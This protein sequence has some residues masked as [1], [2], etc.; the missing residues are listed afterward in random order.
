MLI[1][2]EN[3]IDVVHALTLRNSNLR[4]N[5]SRY[6]RILSKYYCSSR[7]LRAYRFQESFLRF[8]IHHP[9]CSSLFLKGF[10]V[11]ICYEKLS[12]ESNLPLHYDLLFRIYLFLC[13]PKV[14]NR[15]F[16][17][18]KK[19]FVLLAPTQTA[20]QF[21]Q[22]SPL[23]T[24][25]TPNNAEIV[26][27]NSS[28]EYD[29][30]SG[31]IPTTVTFYNKQKL[32][33]IFSQ[34]PNFFPS[35]SHVFVKP[36]SRFSLI[37]HF[38]RKKMLYSISRHLK[39]FGTEYNGLI[40]IL[41]SLIKGKSRKIY[42]FGFDL[43][44]QVSRVKGYSKQISNKPAP[45]SRSDFKDMFLRSASQHDPAEQ[46]M[47]LYVL[48]KLKYFYPDKKLSNILENGLYSY[49]LNLSRSYL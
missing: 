30:N 7:F 19:N 9:F 33:S 26:R 38:K 15:C 1:R 45:S 49:L 17:P 21:F 8:Y 24:I 25:I 11:L 47:I 23:W 27:L 35:A 43:Q 5:F 20:T 28:P 32:I 18:L 6:K 13:R 14:L 22:E 44:L 41:L 16:L 29:S 39:P 34:H 42:T 12:K 40:C 2:L 46:F 3:F 4:S 36:S 37:T 31:T 10:I 48:Y